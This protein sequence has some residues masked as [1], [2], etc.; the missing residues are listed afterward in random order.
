M[1]REVS[2]DE[3]ESRLMALH[4]GSFTWALRCCGGDHSEAEDVLQS[5]YV[6]I[7]EG[8]A[9]YRGD[10]SLKTWLYAVIR[11]TAADRQRR[12]ARRQRILAWLGAAPAAPVRTPEAALEGAL[13]RER[14]ERARRGLTPRQ[15]QVLDL[16]FEHDLSLS[17]SAAV[18]GISVGS[19]RTHYDRAKKHLRGVLGEDR[20]D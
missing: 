3:L 10:A 1:E 19:A 4:R 5:T 7:L 18:L 20:D 14:L 2:P 8:R 12:R 6:K 11:R 13:E 17:E 16:V 15:D 9:R